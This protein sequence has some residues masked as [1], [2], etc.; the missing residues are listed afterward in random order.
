MRESHGDIKALQRAKQALREKYGSR[1]WFRGVGIA[2]SN[3]GIGLRLNVDP[4]VHVAEGEIPKSFRGYSIEVVFIR[5]YE[6]RKV[7]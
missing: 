4:A 2:P 3:A 7:K 6:P 1:D 5:G